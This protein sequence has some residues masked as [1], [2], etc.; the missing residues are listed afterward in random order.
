MGPVQ[1]RRGERKVTDPQ[2]SPAGTRYRAGLGFSTVLPDLDFETYSEAGYVFDFERQKWHGPRNAPKG[3]AGLEVVGAAVYATHPTAEVL[4]LSYNLKDGRGPRL[5]VPGHEAP[6]EL[7]DHIGRGGLLEAWNSAFE[8]WIWNYVCTQ[9]YGWPQLP[10]ES[11]RCAMAKARAFSLPGKL[12]ITGRVLALPIQK[13]ADGKRLLDKFSKP[14]NP[15]KADKRLRIT[16]RDDPADAGKLA[17]YNL[18]DIEAE[19]QASARCPDL[20]GEELEFWLVD[21]KI[22]RRG[23][24]VDEDGLRACADVVRM[25][26]ERYDAELH[27]LTGGAV[28][29][30][31]QLER[32]RGWLAGRGVHIPDG[33]G[34]MDDEAIDRYLQWRL[35][36]ASRRALEIRQTV[37]SASVKKVFAMLNGLSPWGRLHDLY[38]YHGARTGRPTGEGPQPTNLPKAGPPVWRCGCGRH[39]GMHRH[40]CAWCGMPRGPAV[41]ATEWGPDGVEDVLQVMQRRNLSLLEDVFGPAMLCVSGCLRGMFIASE[42]HDL[43]ASDFSAIES[44]VTACLAGEQWRVDVFATHGKNYEMAVSQ[45]SGLPFAEVMAHAGYTDTTSPEWWT[46]RAF[47]GPH[48]PLRQTLGK[49]SELASGFGGWINAWKNFGA[50]DFMSDDEIKDAIL[51]WRAGSPAIVEFWGGQERREGWNRYPELFGLEGMAVKAVLQ[52]G[53]PQPVMRKDGTH[54]GITYLCDGSILYCMLPSGRVLHYHN[55]ILEPNTRGWGGDY[56]LTFEGYNTNPTQGPVGWVRMNTYGGKLC[57]NVVQ[58]VARDIQRHAMVNCYRKGW[59]IALHIYDEIVID[60]PSGSVSVAD[61]EA[62]MRTMPPWAVYKGKPW[63]IK[64]AGGWCGKRYRKD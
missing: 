49:V 4:T 51:K 54:S 13:D 50:D 60:V 15:T 33:P 14:R 27:Q 17:A 9:R 30:A 28:E 40:V 56:S 53:Q 8:W 18:T 55:P 46:R 42:G 20:T 37:G 43:V 31:S 1:S 6:Q 19:A 12:E 21:Q 35:D 38:N 2:H 36:P 45:I 16:L 32:L 52:S 59:A 11:L 48:H 22:N 23:V 24:R 44:V 39:S 7:F 34:T 58:A 26:L 64:A 5:W 47:K 29:R 41:E 63:P 10:V 25:C 61:L 3:K 62:V 57:E